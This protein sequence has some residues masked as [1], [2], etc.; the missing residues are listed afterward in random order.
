MYNLGQHMHA[1]AG[2]LKQHMKAKAVVFLCSF[3]QNCCIN[4]VTFEMGCGA[5]L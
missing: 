1:V 4:K 2:E 5:D 3:T